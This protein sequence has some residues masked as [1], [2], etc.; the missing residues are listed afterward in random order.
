MLKT[1]SKA[2]IDFEIS[3]DHLTVNIPANNQNRQRRQIAL[4]GLFAK[5][6]TLPFVTDPAELRSWKRSR[7]RMITE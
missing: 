5:V 7:R 1:K 6:L 2:D 4:T 3:R